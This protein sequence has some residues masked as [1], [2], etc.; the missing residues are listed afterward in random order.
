MVVC[1][2]SFRSALIAENGK[3]VNM[4]IKK[5]KVARGVLESC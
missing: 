4:P 5:K 3:I 1:N 2:I